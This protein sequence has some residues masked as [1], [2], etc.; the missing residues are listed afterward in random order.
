MASTVFH[1]LPTVKRDGVI[2]LFKS[3]DK[4]YGDGEQK[5]D[6]IYVKDAARMTCAFLDNKATGLF[7]IGSGRAETWNE[8]AKAVFKAAHQSPNIQYIDMPADLLGKYQNYTCADMSKTEKVL[9]SETRCRPL[10]E[11]VVEYVRDYLTPGA[12]W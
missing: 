11:T 5:R 6:F 4:Q 7:N 9:G 12:T 3:N 8:L 1:F 2:R 10:E